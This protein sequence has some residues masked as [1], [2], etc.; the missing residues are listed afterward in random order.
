MN[1]KINS[2]E[3]AITLYNIQIPLLKDLMLQSHKYLPYTF[4]SKSCFKKHEVQ[5]DSSI[6]HIS[7][8]LLFH[9]ELI[10]CFSGEKKG[11]IVYKNFYDISY[12]MNYMLDKELEN[13]KAGCINLCE[14]NTIIEYFVLIHTFASLN[15]LYNPSFNYGTNN[16]SNELIDKVSVPDE[17]PYRLEN[18]LL[19]LDLLLKN[20]ENISETDFFDCEELYRQFYIDLIYAGDEE[21]VYEKIKRKLLNEKRKTSKTSIIDE[22]IFLKNKWAEQRKKANI[23]IDN[24][25]DS[26]KKNALLFVKFV[27]TEEE[28]R[29]KIDTKFFYFLGKLL[30]KLEMDA[31]STTYDSLRL[32][33]RIYNERNNKYG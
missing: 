30:N 24:C 8:W 17:I 11:D 19:F 14:I 25:V 2:T 4:F 1:L 12:K 26:I 31:Q 9:N 29:H 32:Q 23:I 18:R 33:I 27:C 28:V 3:V 6:I 22:K 5:K 7:E 13:L 16:W 15:F 10:S 20:Y 21:Y